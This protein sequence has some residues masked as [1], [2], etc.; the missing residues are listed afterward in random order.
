ML[1][2]VTFVG[3]VVLGVD[4]VVRR[5]AQLVSWLKGAEQTVVNEVKVVGNTVA[6]DIKKVL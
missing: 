6:D 3:V 4:F 5:G 2:V 1:S